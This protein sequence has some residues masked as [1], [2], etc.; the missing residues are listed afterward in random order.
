MSVGTMSPIYY[1]PFDVELDRNV[2]AMWRRMR[3]EQPVYWNEQ[4]QFYAFSRFEDVWAAYHDPETFSSSHGVQLETLDTPIEFPMVIFM[5]PPEHDVMRKL[6][7]RAFTPRRIA[8]LREHIDELV[9]QYLDPFVGTSGFDFVADFGALLPPMVIG[10]MLGLPADERDMVRRWFDEMLHRDEGQAVGATN[11]EAMAAGAKMHQY[12]SELIVERR[13]RPGDDMIST[14]IESEVEENGFSRKLTDF[15]LSLFVVL[16]A[17]AGVE[18]VARLLSW[19]G[20]T[21]AR[22]PD[23]LALLA[24]DPSLVPNAIEEVL[25][26]EAPSPVNGRFTLKPYSLHGIDIPA[27]SKVLLLNGSANRDPREYTDPDAFDVRRRIQRHI[28]FGFGAHFCLGAA[29]ARME[30]QIALAGAVSRFPRWEVDE[31]RL[32]PVQTSTV[33]GYSSVPIT[34]R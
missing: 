28:T 7:S 32:V 22:N 17:G 10:H 1:D 13:K 27:G 21:L 9:G 8:A 20:V 3:E 11:D 24:A 18:T 31:S 15:E 26:Y 30:G 16:L 33:R 14:L 19:T 12:A 34:L 23:Q 4:Y 6:V 29:L 5:D 25:R 2:H